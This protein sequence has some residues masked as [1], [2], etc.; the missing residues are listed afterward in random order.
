M[1][2]LVLAAQTQMVM[3]AALVAQELLAQVEEAALLDTLETEVMVLR[4]ILVQMA[5]A[6]VVAAVDT[7]GIAAVLVVGPLVAGA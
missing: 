6:V 1:V 7:D 2:V 4:A 3:V 5:L